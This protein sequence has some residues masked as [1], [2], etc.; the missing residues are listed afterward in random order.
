MYASNMMYYHI[1]IHIIFKY[2]NICKS[3]HCLCI[4][5][6]DADR[7]TIS[8]QLFDDTKLGI[9]TQDP[10]LRWCKNFASFDHWGAL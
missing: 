2:Y 1:H 4:S 5:I 9:W 7:K 3:F 6:H 8:Q 10:F